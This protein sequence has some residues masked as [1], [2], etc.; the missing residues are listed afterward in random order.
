MNVL[1]LFGGGSTEHEV[2]RVSASYIYEV[3][4]EIKELNPILVEIDDKGTWINEKRPC[5]LVGQVLKTPTEQPYIDYIIPCLHGAPGETGQIQGLFEN[6]LIPYFGQRSEASITCF[7]KVLTKL[8]LDKMKIA[9]SPWMSV[10]KNIELDNASI[11]NFFDI[12]KDIFI[13]A[14]SQ[15]SSIGCYHVKERKDVI[16]TIKKAF[17]FSDH[18]LIEK[19][20]EGRELEISVFEFEGE[21]LASLP[22]EIICSDGFY[23]YEQKYSKESSTK[24]DIV[25]KDIPKKKMK[26]MADVAIRV[27][28]YFGLRHLARVDFFLHE[29]TVYLNEINTF[30][31]MTP[32]SMFPKMLEKKL[33]NKQKNFKDYLEKIIKSELGK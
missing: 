21:V 4:G 24:I 3:V 12:H 19:T 11:L 1:I 27:F 2:S 22:G 5:N 26:E 6:N 28:K 14:A 7:N 23:D 10:H 13:K 20:I 15:G 31:G 25:A 29:E 17:D 18:V 8:L 9:N 30:P 16:P 33:E 32:I